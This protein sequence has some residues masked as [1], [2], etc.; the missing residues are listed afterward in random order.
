MRTGRNFVPDQTP[1]ISAFHEPGDART[2]PFARVGV[3]EV[4]EIKPTKMTLLC[5]K[6]GETLLP[7][8]NHTRNPR[9]DCVIYGLAPNRWLVVYGDENGSLTEFAS[10]ILYA[11]DHSDAWAGLHVSG[12]KAADVIQTLCPV[13]MHPTVFGHGACFQSK[14]GANPTLVA[15]TPDGFHIFIPRSS[16]RAVLED[17]YRV[18]V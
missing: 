14:L 13:D 1:Q 11:T 18:N 9:P 16:A 5:G 17:I 15:P 7:P 10:P 3:L 4:V 2:L 8:T 12:K 6:P